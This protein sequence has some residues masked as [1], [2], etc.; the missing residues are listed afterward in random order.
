[1]LTTL[2]GTRAATSWAPDDDRWYSPIGVQTSAGLKVTPQAAASLNALMACVRVISETLAS[3]PL[4]IYL[5]RADGGKDRA[6]DHPMYRTLKF[7][8][9]SWQTR[10][11]WVEMLQGHILL[12]GNAFCQIVPTGGGEAD[13]I[14][15]NPDRMKVEQLENGRLRYTW[16]NDLGQDTLFN[17]DEIFHLR[18]M[19]FSGLLGLDPV[20]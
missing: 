7:E 16:K 3:F 17:Q 19:S 18:G 13:L 12:R 20:E 14:P 5:N 11:E 4:I 2:L 10:F 1:M 15:L 9:N 8:P 6:E